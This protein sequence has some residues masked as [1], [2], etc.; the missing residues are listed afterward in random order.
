MANNELVLPV[1]NGIG[2]SFVIAS[3]IVNRQME[4]TGN[5]KLDG[6][7]MILSAISMGVFIG[8]LVVYSMMK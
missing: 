7:G 6:V 4:K 2:L 1:L 5:V 3:V 8:G